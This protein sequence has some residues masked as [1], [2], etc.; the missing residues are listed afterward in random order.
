MVLAST[1]KCSLFKPNQGPF[2]NVSFHV[3]HFGGLHEG[4]CTYG[5]FLIKQFLNDSQLEAQT[6]GPYCTDTEPN[7]PLTGTD[8]LV[9]LVFGDAG[10]LDY[11]CERSVI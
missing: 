8:G 6:L 2:P 9:Y 4:G 1:I 10:R 5:G 7:H 11:L 3:Q